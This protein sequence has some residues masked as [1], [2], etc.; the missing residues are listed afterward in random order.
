MTISENEAIGAVVGSFNATD[1]DAG[2]TLTYSLVSG[3]GDGNNSLFTLET[4][5]TLKAAVIF[6]Y[7]SNASTY[8]I[9]VQ[10]KDEFN[11][12]VEGNFTVTLTDVYE[13]SQPNHFVD[14]QLHRESRNDLGGVRYFTMGSPTNEAGRGTDETE[15]QVTLT[16]G[17]YLGKYEVTQAQYEAVMTDNN[18]SLSPTPSNYTGS[19]LPVEQVSWDDIQIFLER[20][21]EQEADNLPPGWAYVLPTE[22]QWEYA[23]RAGTTTAY[24]WGDEINASLANYDSNIGQTA[25]VGSYGA[26]PWGFFD[27][28]GNVW[29]WCG[30]LDGPYEV[31]PLTDPMGSTSGIESGPKR[32]IMDIRASFLTICNAFSGSY[33]ATRSA[34][35]GFRVG[36]PNTTTRPPTNLNLSYH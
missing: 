30:D 9:R 3:V 25:N 6:D 21:N 17:F 28:H 8:S 31:G 34:T 11:A 27:M 29:E 12:T 26:N 22:A 32:W 14:L 1:P 7:E 35:H 19:D 2:A 24:S 23:C 13:P 5:G 4:N 18:A 16:Q 20:L 33:P 36:L 15:T 10:A